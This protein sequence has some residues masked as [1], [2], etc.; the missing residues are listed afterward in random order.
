[1]TSN[2]YNRCVEFYNT[3]AELLDSRNL[4][5][6]LDLLTEDVQYRAPIRLTREAGSDEAEFS[7]QSFH[8]KDNFNT[9]KARVERFQ[10]EYA[11][12]E[13]PPSRTRRFVSNIRVNDDGDGPSAKTNLMLTRYQ[14]ENS[15]PE[16]IT[17][18][19]IDKLAISNEDIKL[20][21]RTI[22]LDVTVVGTKNFSIFL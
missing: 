18:E 5:E 16:F 2:L 21:E 8:F 14:G 11:W 13:N 6:W 12:A 15:N 1:M 20:Q 19:R 3:E 17:C 7:D 10:K 9:L 22:L 4:E